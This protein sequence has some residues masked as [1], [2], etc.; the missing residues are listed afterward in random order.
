M[1]KNIA[2]LVAKISL[3][4][5]LHVAAVLLVAFALKRDTP[6]PFNM[7]CLVVYLPALLALA[8]HIYIIRQY[9]R[10]RLERTAS[11]VAGLAFGILPT[12]IGY[13]ASLYVIMS[14]YGS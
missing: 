10:R 7:G 5:A 12:V 14:I 13:A 1:T 11:F 6:A 8:G 3:V 9:A 2:P 4:T